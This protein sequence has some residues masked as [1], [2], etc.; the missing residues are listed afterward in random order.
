MGKSKGQPADTTGNPR[1]LVAM[2]AI[3]G[4][5]QGVLAGGK[6][7]PCRQMTVAAQVDFLINEAQDIDNLTRMWFPWMPLF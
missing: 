5:L 6:L 1:A 4:K 3:Q 2:A 7:K